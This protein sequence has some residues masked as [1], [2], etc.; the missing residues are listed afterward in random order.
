MELRIMRKNLEQKLS[1]EHKV[2]TKCIFEGLTIAQIAAKL[3][4]SQSTVANRLNTLFKKYSA[5]TRIEFILAVVGE[6]ID[7]YKTKLFVASDEIDK[8]KSELHKTKKTLLSLV[9][10]VNNRR[11]YEKNVLKAKELLKN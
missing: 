2:I 8:L 7:G 4:Y 10:S 6:V 1:Q 11:E 5:K 9:N 3:S